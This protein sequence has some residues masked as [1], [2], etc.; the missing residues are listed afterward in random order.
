MVSAKGS[1][2]VTGSNGGLG[3]GIVKH[4]LGSSSLATN[5]HGIYTVRDTEQATTVK[6]ILQGAAS[7]GHTY[8][9]ISL[10]LSSLASTRKAAEDINKRVADGSIPPI[11]ALI[12]NAGWQEYT[13]HTITEDGFDMSFQANY[14]SH[15]LLTLLL[16]R[17][18]DKKNGRVV[19]LG[20]WTHDTSDK[21]NIVPGF[22]RPYE[23][24]QWNM[25]FKEPVDTEPLARGKWSTPA[26]DEPGSRNPGYRR[27]GAGKLCEIMFMR[28]LAKRV[29]T[30]PE[31]SSIAVLGVDPGA[32]PTNLTRRGAVPFFGAITAVMGFVVS[33][34]SMVVSNSDLRSAAQ[35]A[36]DVMNAS[37]DTETLGKQPNGIYLNGCVVGEVGPEA[38]DAAK[39]EKLWVDSLR[40]AQVKE[41]DTVLTA[42]R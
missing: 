40:F 2:L 16:L 31:L 30:D 34:L 17:S 18:M 27:Y 39:C 3:S 32:M 7:A 8:D 28:E 38:K 11:R 35:S 6:N 25:I 26:Q 20:S 29:S 36:N 22:V 10:E 21:R 5:Y 42:W 12:L 23:D 14:L 1:I 4:I 33:A 9:L 15:F 13:T 41:G 19:V 24:E 37:F